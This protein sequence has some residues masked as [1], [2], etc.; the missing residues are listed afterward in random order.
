MLR[1]TGAAST[2]RKDQEEA[3]GVVVLGGNPGFLSFTSS[4]DFYGPLAFV[5]TASPPFPF[6]LYPLY[7]H[8]A[9]YSIPL[10]KKHPSKF[11]TA[12]HSLSHPITLFLLFQN[13]S[14]SSV[15]LHHLDRL[16]RV[17]DRLA[18]VVAGQL[19]GKGQQCVGRCRANHLDRGREAK[20]F[21]HAS[22]SPL[23][24]GRRLALG[25]R[26]EDVCPHDFWWGV[27]GRGKGSGWVGR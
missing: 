6:N 8:N 1:P 20:G 16:A 5:A 7:A 15:V 3:K 25:H 18:G 9:N 22:G 24:V 12:P 2:R 14:S 19:R 13:I 27:G 17:H 4:K 26:V 23:L 10:S 11:Y 21:A